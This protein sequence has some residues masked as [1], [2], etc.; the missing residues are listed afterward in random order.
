[1]LSLPSESD[2]DSVFC[3]AHTF[4][5]SCSSHLNPT[6]FPCFCCFSAGWSLTFTGPQQREGNS[7]NES[8]CLTVVPVSRD[9]RRVLSWFTV[10]HHYYRLWHRCFPACC[11]TWVGLHTDTANKQPVTVSH[12]VCTLSSWCY[13]TRN[14][15]GATHV[16]D[17]CFLNV[18]M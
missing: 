8:V 16:S 9:I 5:S 15:N 3:G 12:V 18:S 11:I 6:Y 10:M 7:Q 17:S 13:L 4:Y 1:M 2:S 14:T